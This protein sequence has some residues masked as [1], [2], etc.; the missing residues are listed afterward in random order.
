[1]YH[2]MKKSYREK[3]K[4]HEILWSVQRAAMPRVHLPHPTNAEKVSSPMI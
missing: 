1:M 4:F 2:K 3:L